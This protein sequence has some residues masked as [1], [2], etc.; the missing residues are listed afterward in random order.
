MLSAGPVIDKHS[1]QPRCSL[2]YPCSD[3]YFCDRTSGAFGQCI[4][5]EICPKSPKGSNAELVPNQSGR[6]GSTAE[7]ICPDGYSLDFGTEQ[8]IQVKCTT[9]GWVPVNS[10][11]GVLPTCQRSKIFI[12]FF[13]LAVKGNGIIGIYLLDTEN[14][15]SNS[16]D[17]LCQRGCA[18]NLPQF[19][20]SVTPVIKEPG[21]EVADPDQEG[22]FQCD[23]GF[24]LHRSLQN[25]GQNP[26]QIHVVCTESKKW[27]ILDH[28]HDIDEDFD[29]LH[30]LPCEKITSCTV[31]TECSWK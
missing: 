4:H 29:D 6:V 18:F 8:T 16:D 11:N 27:I 21:Q 26:E 19:V 17:P 15:D 22:V 2:K 28:H 9:T 3:G 7:M 5:D 25:D 20:G 10:T 1:C 30:L 12:Q 23:P 14:C 31:N 13:T 24:H